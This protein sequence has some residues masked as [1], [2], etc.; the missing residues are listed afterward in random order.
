MRTQTVHLRPRKR[1]R[2]RAERAIHFA[3]T[4]GGMPEGEI[5]EILQEIGLGPIRTYRELTGRYRDYFA[6]DVTR[7][8]D[9]I[10]HPPTFT[11]V[12]LALRA[13]QVTKRDR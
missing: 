1:R 13:E 11:K 7:L 8:A 4:L 12:S 5:N 9:A 3:C 6:Q 10:R 2:L